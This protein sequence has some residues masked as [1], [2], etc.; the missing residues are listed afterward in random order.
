[1]YRF[2][3]SSHLS[4]PSSLGPKYQY[5]CPW[6]HFVVYRE[7]DIVEHFYDSSTCQGFNTAKQLLL[8][9]LPVDDRESHFERKYQ[10]NQRAAQPDLPPCRP[11]VFRAWLEDWEEE[12]LIDQDDPLA[13]RKLVAKY[14]GLVVV[15]IHNK[16]EGG[17]LQISSTTADYFPMKGWCVIAHSP[18][19]RQRFLCGGKAILEGVVEASKRG[20]NKGLV[21]IAS[22]EED[23]GR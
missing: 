22:K 3:P 21:V 5:K 14:E 10:A 17:P 4:G 18:T 8:Q 13:P 15:D 1:M 23:D 7:D 12:L 16:E 19:E 6:C 11:G 20:L 2:Q 9:T